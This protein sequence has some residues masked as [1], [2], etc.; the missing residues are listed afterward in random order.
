MILLTEIAGM[1]VEKLKDALKSH[2]LPTAGKKAELA[3]RL[4]EYIEKHSNEINETTKGDES[5]PTE[6]VRSNDVVESEVATFDSIPETSDEPSTSVPSVDEK[7]KTPQGSAIF[8]GDHKAG[9]VD[10]TEPAIPIESAQ[11]TDPSGSAE[12]AKVVNSTDSMEPTV[13]NDNNEVKFS[14]TGIVPPTLDSNEASSNLRGASAVDKR[15]LLE[16]KLLREKAMSS[17][18]ARKTGHIA[19][20]NHN[21]GIDKSSEIQSEVSS[22]PTLHLRINNFQRPLTLGQLSVYIEDLGTPAKVEDKNSSEPTQKCV[23]NSATQLWVSS[24]KTHCYVTFNNIEE[25]IA[26]K[27]K[28]D[29][30]IHYPSSNPK[31][32]SAY[33]T[34]VPVAGL[35][36]ASQVKKDQ[37]Q[38]SADTFTE[39]QCQRWV[40]E[41][42]LKPMEWEDIYIHFKVN[43]NHAKKAIKKEKTLVVTTVPENQTTSKTSSAG[44]VT[45]KHAKEFGMAA[46]VLLG[47]K[48]SR[49]VAVG[50]SE[51]LLRNED[52]REL[53]NDCKRSK[54]DS[55]GSKPD[56]IVMDIDELFNKTTAAPS[57]YWCAVEP[58]VQDSRWRKIHAENRTCK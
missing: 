36:H 51:Y 27:V 11:H 14:I 10:S 26:C 30:G 41:A 8:A 9:A 46:A 25:S 22:E 4:R 32:L 17:I 55:Y 5:S 31:Q 58:S 56:A 49:E 52:A 28:I 18:I 2:D 20:H 33:Y 12:L 24:I 34:H 19:N 47:S 15:Q 23:L 16:E 50:S 13:S 38:T 45:K 6:G 21:A 42:A 54:R 37:D 35:L 29:Q 39:E 48:R 43:K 1:T 7:T 57:L 44:F 53:R 40:E 3:A